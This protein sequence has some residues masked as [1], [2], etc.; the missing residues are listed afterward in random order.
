MVKNS[1]AYPQHAALE[2]L[3]PKAGV[4]DVPVPWVQKF[5]LT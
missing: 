1:M 4:P 2:G 3:S 5:R